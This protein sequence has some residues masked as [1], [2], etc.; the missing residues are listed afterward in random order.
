MNLWQKEERRASPRFNSS[1]SSLGEIA[2]A[3]MRWL[4]TFPG[5]ILKLVPDERLQIPA[6]LPQAAVKRV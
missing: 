3:V 1:S 6:R 5:V 2:C 4:V